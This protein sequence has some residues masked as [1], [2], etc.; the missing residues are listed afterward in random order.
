MSTALDNLQ[1]IVVLMMENR[2][3]DHMLGH[4]TL[5]DPSFPVEGLKKADL[6]NGTYTNYYKGDPYP[7]FQL[8]ND[9]DL[10]IDI[11][12]EA[13]FV[14]IQMSKNSPLDNPQEQ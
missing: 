11:P 2:S 10:E 8:S 5:D 1:H 12:H 13:E 7:L 6:E 3:F 9:T 14:A 4:L